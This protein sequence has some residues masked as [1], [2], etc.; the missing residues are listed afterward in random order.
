MEAQQRPYQW[1][2]SSTGKGKGQE[3]GAQRN[4]VRKEWMRQEQKQ[5]LEGGDQVFSRSNSWENNTKEIKLWGWSA[6]VFSPLLLLSSPFPLYPTLF[7]SY[8]GVLSL[9][10]ILSPWLCI[11]PPLIFT[12]ASLFQRSLVSSI[13]SLPH[14]FLSK[15]IIIVLEAMPSLYLPHSQISGKSVLPSTHAPSACFP[16]APQ[17]RVASVPIISLNPLWVRLPCPPLHQAMRT[18]FNPYIIGSLWSI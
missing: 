6:S 16:F 4:K 2:A 11:T 13:S 18:V 17:H 1:Q 12:T 14:G 9:R 10:C 8:E 15:H 3:A 7:P 5:T